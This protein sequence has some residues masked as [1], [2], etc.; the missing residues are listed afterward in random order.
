MCVCVCLY[1]YTYIYLF[2][3][4]KNYNYLLVFLLL[5][6]NLAKEAHSNQEAKKRYLFSWNRVHVEFPVPEEKKE[7]LLFSFKINNFP[8]E[9]GILLL[10]IWK[11]KGK[12]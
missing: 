2:D 8:N 12:K 3:N 11:G 10:Q 9:S 5:R 4:I 7:E 1:I 6:G